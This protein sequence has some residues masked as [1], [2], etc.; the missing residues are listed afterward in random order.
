MSKKQPCKKCGAV[1]QNYWLKDGVC[2]GCRNP[3]L[4]VVAKPAKCTD[5]KPGFACLAH[6]GTHGN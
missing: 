6:W 1:L 5:C 3:H 2:N 4:I